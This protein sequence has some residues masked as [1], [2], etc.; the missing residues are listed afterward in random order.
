MSLRDVEKILKNPT[1][2]KLLN[3]S[4][5]FSKAI[6]PA[7]DLLILWKMKGDM[8]SSPSCS[9]PYSV[10]RR[11]RFNWCDKSL[12]VSLFLTKLSYY[13]RCSPSLHSME[14]SSFDIFLNII[15]CSVEER[16]NVVF[17]LIIFQWI[18][19][20]LKEWT[21]ICMYM[22]MSMLIYLKL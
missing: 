12:N 16:W 19:S 8:Y 20:P 21:S 1:D 6:W 17:F 11:W 13:N 15:F 9:F 3:S 4:V 14:K 10:I 18:L 7:Y 5:C 2:L 22:C